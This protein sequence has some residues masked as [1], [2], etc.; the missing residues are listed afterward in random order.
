M[1]NLY[2]RGENH[3]LK[4]WNI[5]YLSLLYLLNFNLL[6]HL[7]TVYWEPVLFAGHCIRN[8]KMN[9]RMI[10]TVYSP[11]N[12]AWKKHEAKTAGAKKRNR[13]ARS[14]SWEPWHSNLSKWWDRTENQ[15]RRSR[16]DHEGRAGPAV[17]TEHSPTAEHTFPRHTRHAQDG[18]QTVVPKPL[19]IPGRMWSPW[20]LRP[21]WLALRSGLRK[22]CNDNNSDKQWRS[23]NSKREPRSEAH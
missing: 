5:S 19:R 20:H 10:L 15:Q 3:S 16:P 23:A 2:N 13:Q 7:G 14:W 22:H 8:T 6:S 18:L 21:A 11:N 4:K 12:R 1:H 9:K 17:Y